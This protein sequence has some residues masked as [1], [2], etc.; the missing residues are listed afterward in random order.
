MFSDETYMKA[1]RNMLLSFLLN[2]LLISDWLYT[3]HVFAIFLP[4][5]ICL[6]SNY[7]N[8]RNPN[9]QRNKCIVIVLIILSACLNYFACLKEHMSFGK[10]E[11]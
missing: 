10:L 6:N 4:V 5:I 2:S 1:K 8:K 7:E 11:N 3:N 9:G